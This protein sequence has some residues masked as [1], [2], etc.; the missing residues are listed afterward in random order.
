MIYLILI[1]VLFLI[2]LELILL[3]NSKRIGNAISLVD[4]P[5][6]IRKF[7]K[8]PVPL[9]GGLILCVTI[10]EYYLNHN[11]SS[12]NH[13]IFWDRRINVI[14]RVRCVKGIVPNPLFFKQLMKMF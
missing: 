4:I 1:V 10:Y 12:S 9:V 5:D 3:I 6:E 2:T 11:L 13:L 8:N 7:H 14:F